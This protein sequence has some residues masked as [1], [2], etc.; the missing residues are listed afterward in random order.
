VTVTIAQVRK[1][2]LALPETSEVVT[3]ETDLTWRV[4]D[5]IFVMGGPKSPS[6]TVKTSIQEQT[7]LIAMA[8]QTYEFAAYVGRFGWTSI[9]LSTVDRDELR[10]LVVEAWRRTA[11]KKLVAAFDETRAERRT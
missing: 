2:A 6:V 3:W 9:R 11:P 1:M 5:K 10:D 4:R 8:P 7:E